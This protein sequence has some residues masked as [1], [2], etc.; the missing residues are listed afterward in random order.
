[1]TFTLVHT[2]KYWT[3]DK[4]KY[5]QY[6]NKRQTSKSKP[7][8]TQQNKWYSHFLRHSA[9]KGGGLILH[10]SRAYKGPNGQTYTPYCHT[11]NWI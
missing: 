2:G 11:G 10:C 6:R 1:V 7:C 4:L 8:K 5:T 3:E 9:R